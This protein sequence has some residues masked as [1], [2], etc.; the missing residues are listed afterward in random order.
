MRI[1]II[2]DETAATQNLISIIREVCHEGEII[3]TI[4][5]VRDAVK[6]F[7]SNPHPDLVFMDI[8]LA[9]GDAFRIFEQTHI[10][11][12]IIFTT[13]YD[14]YALEAFHVNSI[15]YLLKPIKPE[16]MQRAM[17]KLARLTRSDREAY[18][19]RVSQMATYHNAGGF[20]VHVKDKIIPIKTSEIAFFYT[21][22]E[23]VSITTFDGRTLPYDKPLDYIMSTL[24][25]NDFFRANRQ[26]IISRGAVDEISVWFG[27]RLTVSLTVKTPERIVISKARVPEFKRWLTIAR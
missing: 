16:D 4:E 12:P 23:R 26:F 14:N 8:H 15:D 3:A 22:Q 2:E 11:S 1:V 9:D 17:D 13:A 24:S 18:S 5:S 6:W 19:E 21:T 7:T 27:S 10:S 20:L 25:E